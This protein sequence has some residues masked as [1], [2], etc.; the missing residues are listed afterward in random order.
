MGLFLR[1]ETWLTD[2]LEVDERPYDDDSDEDSQ[3]VRRED[4]EEEITRQ[5][6]IVLKPV[7]DQMNAASRSNLEFNLVCYGYL[8]F[9]R[10]KC[11]QRNNISLGRVQHDQSC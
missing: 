9:V 11:S 6:Q 1:R 8:Q 3:R 10:A 2:I 7:W 4:Q 5:S